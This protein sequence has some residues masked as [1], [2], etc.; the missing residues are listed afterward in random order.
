MQAPKML[1]TIASAVSLLTV[2]APASAQA[3]TTHV[4]IRAKSLDAKFIGA[5]TGGVEVTLSNARTGA[6]LSRGLIT[7]GTGD[8]PRIMQAPRSRDG[9][10][11]DA[12]TAGFDAVL[13]L[14]EPTLVRAEAKGPLGRPASVITVTSM[15]WI[16]PGHDVAGD[17]WELTF[18]GL[19]IEPAVSKGPST[20]T[21]S[22]NVTMMCGC[23]IS[24]GGVWD[25]G[26]FSVDAVVLDHGKMVGK[27]A[28]S[29][30]GKASQFAADLPPLKPGHY[31]LRLVASEAGT[32]NVGVVEQPLDVQPG[33]N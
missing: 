20:L 18:P 25:A 24:P 29:Y 16:L 31:T 33:L 26:R 5:H 17:G 11:S 27:S 30:A 1:L 21:V 22:A 6:L 19:V 7:G 3:E 13:D 4:M 15:M 28:L 2:C 23:P 14:A 9:A 8:T 32:P 12:A 10:I